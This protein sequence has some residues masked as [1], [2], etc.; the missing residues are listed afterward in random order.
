MSWVHLRSVLGH[1]AVVVTALL[2]LAWGA[3]RV[4]S[5]WTGAQK[6]TAAELA[7][8]KSGRLHMEVTLHFAPEAFHMM[9]FQSV[10]RLIEVRKET[11]YLMDVRVED[12]RRLA[13]QYW[14]RDIHPWQGR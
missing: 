9:L 10:G 3:F 5:D 2:L 7:H 11:A 13:R 14:V 1:R 4:W 6:L 8:A 12:A